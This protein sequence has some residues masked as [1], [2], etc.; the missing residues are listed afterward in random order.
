MLRPV[1]FYCGSRRLFFWFFCD[2][3]KAGA[4]QC[5]KVVCFG[6]LACFA[7]KRLEGFSGQ[8]FWMTFT[9]RTEDFPWGL[10]VLRP[11]AWSFHWGVE[12]SDKG[13]QC[14]SANA[15]VG[16]LLVV[17]DGLNVGGYHPICFVNFTPA[18]FK[19]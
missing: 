1:F 12:R 4:S 14:I 3:L 11:Q 13:T 15:V 6:V 7:N 18:A 10:Y 17:V 19:T 8:L 9:S 2:G 5:A 16:R